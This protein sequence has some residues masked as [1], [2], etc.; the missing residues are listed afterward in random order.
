[1]VD[2]GEIQ[3]RLA[4]SDRHPSPSGQ[5]DRRFEERSGGTAARNERTGALNGPG[6]ERMAMQHDVSDQPLLTASRCWA[7]IL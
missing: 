1:M 4:E 6:A 3:V 5:R 7:A 2:A